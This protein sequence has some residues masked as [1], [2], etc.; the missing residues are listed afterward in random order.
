MIINLLEFNTLGGGERFP[1]GSAPVIRFYHGGGGHG[2]RFASDTTKMVV[3][4]NKQ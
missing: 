1:Q 4:W 2:L 3:P